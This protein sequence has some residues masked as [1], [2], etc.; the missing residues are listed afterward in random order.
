MYRR[1]ALD[2]LKGIVIIFMT[3]DYVYF[4]EKSTPIIW[5][6]LYAFVVHCEWLFV[7]RGVATLLNKE[8]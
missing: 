6:F 8:S 2:V 4:W 7:E 1:V 5:I 3:A